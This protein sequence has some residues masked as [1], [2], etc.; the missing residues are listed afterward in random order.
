MWDSSVAG[1]K[2]RTGQE[3]EEFSL[4]S[5]VRMIYSSVSVPDTKVHTSLHGIDS[6]GTFLPNKSMKGLPCHCQE[7]TEEKGL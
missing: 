5:I 1:E 7:A 6:F 2:N 3:T 4:V